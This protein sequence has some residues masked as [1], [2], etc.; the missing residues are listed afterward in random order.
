MIRAVLVALVGA[1]ALAPSVPGPPM[2]LAA[3]RHDVSTPVVSASSPTCWSAPVS[4]PVADPFRAPT[5]PWCPGNRG[6]EYA[7]VPGDGVRSVVDGRVTFDGLVAGRRY[8]TLAVGPATEG[9]RVTIGGL[10]PAGEPRTVGR[11]VRRDEPLGVAVGPVHL[12][13]RRNGSYVDPAAFVDAPL[14]QARLV[15]VDGP[16]GRPAPLRR[17]CG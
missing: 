7:S 17:S 16:P 8:L 5:C 14:R 6:V 9:L 2:R 15:P 10:D 1:L 13:V 4:A 3:P 12:G 11:I